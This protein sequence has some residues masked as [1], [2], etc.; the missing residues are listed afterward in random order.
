MPAAPLPSALEQLFPG[1]DF[2]W[3]MKMRKADPAR[4]FCSQDA[5]GSLLRQKQEIL[6]DQSDRHL[7]FSAAATPMVEPLTAAL[8][9]WGL[10]LEDPPDFASLAA[11]IEPDLVL[12]DQ[13]NQKLVA[14]AV[15]FPSSWRPTDW[16]ER[17]IQEIHEVI[18]RLNPQIGELIARF[19]GELKPGKAFRRANWS[20]TGSPALNYHPA[21]QRPPL[22]PGLELNQVWLRLE[23]QLF[24]AIPGAVV[25]GLRI[26]PIPLLALARRP[27]LWRHLRHALETMPEEVAH[28]KSL[29]Q[30]LPK[31]IRLMRS[32]QAK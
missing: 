20:L 2:A 11:Q 25:M 32:E 13:T 16:L 14:A 22:D 6:K 18:P 29:N 5:S 23:H 26:Q 19:L 10:P 4:F 15:C 12:M 21:L 27:V 31:L 28:Y 9:Q 17:P 8:R 7:V 3:A 30:A 24:T 1:D